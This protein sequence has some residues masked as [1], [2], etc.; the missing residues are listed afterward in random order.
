MPKSSESTS[1]S[2]S[3]IGGDISVIKMEV[4]KSRRFLKTELREFELKAGYVSENPKEV[5]RDSEENWISL[6]RA[7]V[8]L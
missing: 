2:R 4:V 1:F 8:F 6:S 5:A 7:Y 3:A